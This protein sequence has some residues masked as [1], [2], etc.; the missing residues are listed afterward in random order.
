MLASISRIL[1][2]HINHFAHSNLSLLLRDADATV[3][4]GKRVYWALSTGSGPILP[5]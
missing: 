5:F 2:P 1:L 3:I 4:L